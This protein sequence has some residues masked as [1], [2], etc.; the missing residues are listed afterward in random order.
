MQSTGLGGT[1][2]GNGYICTYVQSEHFK[3]I[4]CLQLTVKRP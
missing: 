2:E 4:L 1:N 3:Y